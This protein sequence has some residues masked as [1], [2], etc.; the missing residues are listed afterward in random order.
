MTNAPNIIVE[1]SIDGISRIKLSEPSTYNALS[2]KTLESLI[3][4][5]K[6]LNNE[7]ETKVIIIEGSGKGFSA[8]HDLKEIR[9]L[10]SKS[11]Y[12]KLFN[13][14]SKLMLG[15]I[16]GKKPVIAKV[17]GA[18]F[19]AGCQLVASCDLAVSSDDATFATPGVNIGLFC[20]TPMV[21]VSRKVSRKKTM[22]MILTGDPIDAKYAKEIGLINDHYPLAQLEDE[23]LKLAKKIASKSNLTIKIGKKAFYKQLE[24]PLNKAYKYT[25]KVMTKNMLALDAQEGISAFLEKRD[26]HW[27]NK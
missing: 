21:A 18:A 9:S 25:S 13:L 27:Q 23:V 12:N 4:I 10:K 8:G 19:A 7:N 22:K 14:C 5:F 26:P 6:N 24:M 20:S 2:S 15:I 16:D 3:N 1:P 17:H 11:K